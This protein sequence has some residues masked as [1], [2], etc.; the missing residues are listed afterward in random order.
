M[1]KHWVGGQVGQPPKFFD[2]HDL[3]LGV[4]S[5]QKSFLGGRVVLSFF[6]RSTF[7][8]QGQYFLQDP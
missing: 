2:A 6:R 8:C 1:M 7:G 4:I 5:L 3:C